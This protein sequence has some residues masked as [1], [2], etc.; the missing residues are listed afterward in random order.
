MK[1]TTK[2]PYNWNWSRPIDKDR[3]SI[4]HKWVKFSEELPRNI[5]EVYFLRFSLL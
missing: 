3:K 4:R 2:K 5:S 1:N